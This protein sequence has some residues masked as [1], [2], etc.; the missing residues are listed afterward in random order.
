M[1]YKQIVT[2]AIR[3]APE[4]PGEYIEGSFAGAEEVEG[5]HG[6]YT[7]YLMDVAGAMYWV[8]SASLREAFKLLDSKHKKIGTP[9]KIECTYIDDVTMVGVRICHYRIHAGSLACRGV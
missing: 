7:R 2:P 1:E 5:P 8:Y 3:W 6:L 4:K 9:W